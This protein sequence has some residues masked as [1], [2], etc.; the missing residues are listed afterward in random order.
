M[1]RHGQH[2]EKQLSALQL[3]QKLSPGRYTD[4]SGLYLIVDAS[5]AKRWMLRVVV[6]GRRRDIGLGGVSLV[7]LAEARET[8]GS[9][10]KIA[11]EGGDP[12]SIRRESRKLTPTFALA[13][14]MVHAEHEVT[15]KNAKHAQQWINTLKQYAFPLIGDYRVDTIDTPAVLRVLSPIWLKKPETARRV[16][17]RIGTILDWAKAAGYRTGDNP[18]D[19]IAKGLPKQGEGKKHFATIPFSDVPAFVEKLKCS[20]SGDMAKWAFEFLILTSCRT[21]E[22]LN[23]KWIEI[24]S[25]LWTVPAERM[26][27]K[28]EHRVPLS[29]RCLEI[30]K[31]ANAISK[32]PGYVFTGASGDR[33]LSNMVFLAILKRM[34]IRT[35]AHGFRSSFRDWAAEETSFPREVAEMALAHTITNKVEAAYRR[36]DLLEKR[37]E[38]MQHWSNFV[39]SS[40]H[41]E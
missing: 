22:V 18:I 27:A 33:P 24:D 26:K 17:Q 37:R 19:G 5:G 21:S 11:R 28:R 31:A 20:N 9:L 38:M 25:K 39:T 16:R 32:N 2:P 23:A 36:G 8:A 34:K 41:K 14:E 29:D 3:K 30:L 4:G 7:G 15:W 40:G 12:L 13:A 6:Q 10:R 35:T 1:K